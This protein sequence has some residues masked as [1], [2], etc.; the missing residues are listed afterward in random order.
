MQVSLNR[1]WRHRHLYLLL[2]PAIAYF[3]LYSYAPFWG[4]QIAF[5]H[6]EI[7]AGVWAS[8]WV[9]LE[10]FQ[11]MFGS[12]KFFEVLRNT[13]LLSVYRIVFGFPV[14]I[15]FALLLNEVRAMWFRR[16]VQTITYFPHFLS[17]VVFAGIVFNV[18]G[19]AGMIDS[20]LA[21]LHLPVVSFLTDPR[22][23]RGDLVLTG[24]V[25]E[26]GFSA[27]IYLAALGG[28][29]PQLYEA[30]MV[31]GA[32]KLRQIWHVTLPGLRPIMGVILV[33]SIASLMDGGFDQVFNMYNGAVLQVGDIIDT[34]V[35]RIGLLDAQFEFATAVGIFKGLVG[36]VL[37]VSANH[38]LRRFGERSLW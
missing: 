34:Y 10:H 21:H 28:I 18:M 26:F 17:W 7:F 25:K 3:L 19:P 16:S 20:A 14:P 23:F 15:V 1:V 31:D 38:L 30:A 32:G 11:E 37:V 4:L 8:P 24:I 35:Y 36:L 9:G 33:L 2:L 22:L 27:V 6:F 13:L 12:S 5:K 29:D